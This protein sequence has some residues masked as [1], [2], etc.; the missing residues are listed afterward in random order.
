LIALAY[1]VPFNSPRPAN[2]DFVISENVSTPIGIGSWLAGSLDEGFGMVSLHVV[3]GY[4]SHPLPPLREK[5][6]EKTRYFICP[7]FVHDLDQ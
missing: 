6:Y 7:Q 1:R 3:F 5:P 2:A 4:S